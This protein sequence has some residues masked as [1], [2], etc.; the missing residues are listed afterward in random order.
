M[1]GPDPLAAALEQLRKEIVK[2]LSDFQAVDR[3][4]EDVI[5]QVRTSHAL[6]MERMQAYLDGAILAA[7]QVHGAQ[8]DALSHPPSPS[9]WQLWGDILLT[10]ALQ[11]TLVSALLSRVTQAIFSRLLRQHWALRLLPRTPL[12]NDLLERTKLL[13]A[14]RDKFFRVEEDLLATGSRRWILWPNISS[15]E[16][17]VLAWEAV[18]TAQEQARTLATALKQSL[19][20]RKNVEELG[21][22]YH[23][24]LNHLVTGS[25][26]TAKNLTA[27][28]KA[29]EKAREKLADTGLPL[30]A[31][32]TPTAYILSAVQQYA[33]V[34]RYTMATN[35]AQLENLLRGRRISPDALEP[36]LQ[37]WGLE[38]IDTTLDDPKVTADL[39]LIRQRYALAF[40]AMMWALLYRFGTADAPKYAQNSATLSGVDDRII[41]YWRQRLGPVI[42]EWKYAT[43]QTT[44]PFAELGNK[45]TEVFQIVQYLTEVGQRLQREGVVVP[46]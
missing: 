45:I 34:L 21:K 27:V 8:I 5:L 24:T 31:T 17:V 12:G 13:T 36:L 33:S 41:D 38:S 30:A 35:V 3:L 43:R 32:D 20:E 29:A 10:F 42:D 19:G 46:T 7:F 1:P 6:E 9:G 40:E 22:L 23:S 16:G 39:E 15:N 4:Y 44:R 37:A 18:P 26:V 11:G 25:E 2:A 28:A 14:S